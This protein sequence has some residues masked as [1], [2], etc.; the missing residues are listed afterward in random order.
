M[1]TNERQ[2]QISKAQIAR[3]HAAID[4]PDSNTRTL[5]IPLM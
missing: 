2:H 4:A 3:F 1:I 5:D